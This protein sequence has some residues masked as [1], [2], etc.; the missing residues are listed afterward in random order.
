MAKLVT[1]KEVIP[2]IIILIVGLATL[3]FY[4]CLP[5]KVPSHWNAAGKIDGYMSK[6]ILV[7]FFPS[8]IL[9][10]YLLM[11]G[12]PFIDPLRKNIEKSREA[13]FWLCVILIVFYSLIYLYSLYAGINSENAFPAR[14]FMLSI[15]GLLMISIGSLLPKFKRN[16]FV[17][18]RTPWT[19]HS[20]EV[21]D[22]THQRARKLFTGAGIIL[23]LSTPFKALKFWPLIIMILFALWP[24]V[25]SYFL[26][27]KMNKS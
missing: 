7:I 15:F 10:I 16:Y 20:E 13:Y 5:L 4:P 12:L 22:L 2:I 18:I 3:A 19:L 21:W 6:N 26:Y 14:Y 1:K 27:R 23:I 8:L 9:G 24:V 17:G 11:V 25:D